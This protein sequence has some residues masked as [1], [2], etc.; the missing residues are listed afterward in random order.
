M[1]SEQIFFRNSLGFNIRG[2]LSIPEE[3][4]EPIPIVVFVHGVNS[5]RDSL[6]I[7]AAS[8]ALFNC[9]FASLLLDFTGH[10]ESE[11]TL[12]DSTISQQVDDLENAISWIRA[13]GRFKPIGLFGET[14]GGTVAMR[15]ASE[16]RSIKALVL[17]APRSDTDPSLPSH[18]TIPTLIVQGSADLVVRPESREI[19]DRLGGK[20]YLHIVAGAGHMLDEEHDYLKEALDVASEWFIE[21]LRRARGMKA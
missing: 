15:V 10:G 3:T 12:S 18:I 14:T 1:P 7:R 21:N 20:K 5:S 19:Y 9:S 2:A 13:D 11:G 6:I 4:V 17:Q 8:R 16:D